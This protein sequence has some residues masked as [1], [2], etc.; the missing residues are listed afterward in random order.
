MGQSLTGEARPLVTL[1]ARNHKPDWDG[2]TKLIETWR[3]KGLVVGLPLKMDGGEQE[4]SHAA[5]RFSRQLNGRYHL[6]VHT[7]DERLSTY[8]ARGL[9]RDWGDRNGDRDPVAAQL[10]LETWFTENI[11]S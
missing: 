4:M 2:I 8:E 1:R 3:P 7:M 10:I 9:L 6:P 11:D 5:R